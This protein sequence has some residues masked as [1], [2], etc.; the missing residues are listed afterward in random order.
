MLLSE[1]ALFR[2]FEAK[3]GRIL[4]DGL[5]ISK[6]RLKDLRTRITLIPQ[7]PVLFTGT[8]RDTLDPLSQHTDEELL[9]AL[10]Q[11]HFLRESPN[12]P[13]DTS[14]GP[15]GNYDAF[16]SLD[17]RIHERG[18]NLSQGQRQLLCLARTTLSARSGSDTAPHGSN[19]SHN[20]IIILD[21][22]TSAIDTATDASIQRAF[23]EAFLGAT[24]IVIAH[25]LETVKGFDRVV[26]LH[27]GRLVEQG[28]PEELIEKGGVFKGMLGQSGVGAGWGI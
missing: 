12:K 24:V 10:K 13:G 25:R 14:E 6:L 1:L 8:I 23:R 5:D 3:K 11:V 15:N 7:D 27:E 4:I 16:S 22:A 18:A 28:P 26:V 20:K 19:T 17:F 2:Y 21:E 9:R